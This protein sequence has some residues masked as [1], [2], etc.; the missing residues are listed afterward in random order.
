MDAKVDPE[1][2]APDIRARVENIVD[3]AVGRTLG[4][5]LESTEMDCCVARLRR[6]DGVLNSNGR[7]NGGVISAFIDKVATAAAW[8]NNINGP[9]SRGTTINLTVN[10][11]SAGAKTDLIGTARVTRRGGSVVFVLIDVAD[12]D[13]G[14]VAQGMATYKLSPG[15]QTSRT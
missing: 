14:V 12:E 2:L 7:V 4:F 9:G 15:K 6:S 13:G 5:S 1:G 11:M 8:A 10:Y 3:S